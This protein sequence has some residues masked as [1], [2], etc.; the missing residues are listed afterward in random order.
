MKKILLGLL[1]ALTMLTGNATESILGQLPDTTYKPYATDL[2]GAMPAI[3]QNIVSLVNST[4]TNLGANAVFTG[5]AELITN[6]AE[7]RVS[8]FATPASATDGLQMQQSSDGV[9]WD[10]SDIYSVP[11]TTGKSFGAGSGAAFFRIVYT[12]GVTPT[13]ALR[14]QTT[15][16]YV[17]TKPSATRPQDG[18]SNDNDFE[19]QLSY[20]MGFNGV[21]WDRAQSWN[22]AQIVKPYATTSNEWSYA[23]VTGGIITVTPVVVKAAAGAAIRNYITSLSCANAAAAVATEVTVLDGAVVLWRGYLGLVAQASSIASVQFPNPLKGTA[24]T[25]VNVAI[26]TTAAQVYCN[27]QGFV[28]P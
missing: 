18:R 26:V 20:Q 11:T 19:E 24:N 6:Y 23:A 9:N 15:Y 22:G 17:R 10:N 2:T 7:V 1:L 25:T 3:Y 5:T 21:S 16:H 8:I 28:G 27:L 4:S 14:I 13:T 12:N